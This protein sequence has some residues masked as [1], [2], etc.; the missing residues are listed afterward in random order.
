MAVAITAG[1]S[2]RAAD[3]GANALCYHCA[4]P[5]PEPG[6]DRQGASNGA[7]ERRFCCPGCEAVSRSISDLGLGDYSRLRAASPAPLSARTVDVAAFDDPS[8]QARYV[9]RLDDGVAEAKLLVD[10]MR[11]AACA[12]LVE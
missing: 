8:V 1:A 10:G 6:G 4:L 2:A 9:T 12:W 11:C 5:V 7:G 3:K